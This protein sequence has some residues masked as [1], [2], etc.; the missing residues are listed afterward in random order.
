MWIGTYQFKPNHLLKLILIFRVH[1]LHHFFVHSFPLDVD[2]AIVVPH[3][4]YNAH[5]AR[6][7][8]VVD[9]CE[10]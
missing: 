10:S 3:H 8:N 4:V 6:Q 7:S 5:N 9:V 2:S 1:F